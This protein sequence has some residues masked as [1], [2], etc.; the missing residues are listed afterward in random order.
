MW[1]A[2]LV[3]AL[4]VCTKGLRYKM[5]VVVNFFEHYLIVSLFGIAIF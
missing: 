1:M 4:V 3:S 5:A 2:E